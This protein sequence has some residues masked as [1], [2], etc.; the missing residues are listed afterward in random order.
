[1]YASGTQPRK[2]GGIR[3]LWPMRE[4][5]RFVYLMHDQTWQ[6]QSSHMVQSSHKCWDKSRTELILLKEQGPSVVKSRT[7]NL[8]KLRQDAR[9]QLKMSTV[10][11]KFNLFVF[12]NR[13]NPRKCCSLPV[14]FHLLIYFSFDI[15]DLRH[16]SEKLVWDH[17]QGVRGVLKSI[18]KW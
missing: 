11:R 14:L 9:C 5:A 12:A 8:T 2:R 18:K 13:T 10:T 16:T 1:M 6:V 15:S 3:H 4:R 7:P 17:L